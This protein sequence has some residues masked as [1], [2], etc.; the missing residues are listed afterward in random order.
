MVAFPVCHLAGESS[1]ECWQGQSSATVVAKQKLPHQ[2][3]PT[4]LLTHIQSHLVNAVRL[5][6]VQL[7]P[8]PLAVGMGCGV[9]SGLQHGGLFLL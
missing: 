4:L 2:V 9:P 1:W 3:A 5:C 6:Q 8:K 7:F